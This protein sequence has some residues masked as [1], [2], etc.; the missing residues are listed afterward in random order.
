MRSLLV[1]RLCK[2]ENCVGVGRGWRGAE[3]DVWRGA[4]ESER[5]K[6]SV[7]GKNEKGNET[8]KGKRN[9]VNFRKASS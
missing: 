5:G 4:A 3:G 9:A 7:E 6:R 8:W 1:Q 2:G